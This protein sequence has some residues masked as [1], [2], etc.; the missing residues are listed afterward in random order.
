VSE[1]VAQIADAAIVR[2]SQIKWILVKFVFDYLWSCLHTGARDA[3]G[4]D[5]RKREL[6]D[7]VLALS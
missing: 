2:D 1:C 4:Q 3:H 5:S 7:E 6:L